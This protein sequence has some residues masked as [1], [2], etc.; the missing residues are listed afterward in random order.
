MSSPLNDIITP[1]LVLRLLGD[2]VTDACL[3]G[4]LAT[5]R[6]LL[7]AAIPEEF[8]LN[9]SS[10][11]HDLR[12]LQQ[13]PAYPPWASRA[14]IL[15][16]NKKMIGLIRFHGTPDAHAGQPYMKNA[17]ELGY[18]IFSS[19]R[20]KG[21]AREAINGMMN[22]ATAY[23]LTHRFI[24][25]VSP[26]NIASLALVQSLGFIKADEV[27]DETDGPEYVFLLDKTAS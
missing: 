25:S 24:A 17:A 5:A 14:I 21:Y 19:H 8:L 22:W 7:G 20:R 1:R 4:N 26:E 18:K 10:L 6:D 9:R 3:A 12:Q 13:N 16:D 11:E 2:A 27:M 15:P 23:Y